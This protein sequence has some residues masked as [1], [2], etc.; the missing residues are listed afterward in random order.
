VGLTAVEAELKA[1]QAR[2]AQ[3]E[4]EL[5]RAPAATLGK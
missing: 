5:E 4:A 2:I 1:G 3:L